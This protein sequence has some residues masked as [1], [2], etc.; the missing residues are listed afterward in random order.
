LFFKTIFI[1]LLD[2]VYNFYHQSN[3]TKG[4]GHFFFF[5]PFCVTVFSKPKLRL[6]FSHIGKKGSRMQVLINTNPLDRFMNGK[7]T[8]EKK[9][10]ILMVHSQNNRMVVIF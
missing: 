8:F 5:F 10:L 1:Q 7:V 4:G 3:Q 9:L 2:N 6:F